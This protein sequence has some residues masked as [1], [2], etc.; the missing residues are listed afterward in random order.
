MLL[1]DQ[2][3]QCLVSYHNIMS[4]QGDA[5]KIKSMPK[6]MPG[7]V[8]LYNF[9]GKISNDQVKA[10]RDLGFRVHDGMLAVRHL[11][12]DSDEENGGYF[13]TA[14]LGTSQA[15]HEHRM[16]DG[17]EII[18][19]RHAA[20]SVTDGED[21]SISVGSTVTV[22][23]ESAANDRINRSLRELCAAGL[24]PPEAISLPDEVRN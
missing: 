19:S 23:E 20:D 3:F 4:Q 9:D 1:H 8:H 6:E 13:Y 21:D 24:P 16:T 7:L 12:R 15:A 14:G 2:L 5:K 17:A 11:D 10:L 18:A 22:E